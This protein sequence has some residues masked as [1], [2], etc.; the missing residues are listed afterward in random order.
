MKDVTDNELIKRLCKKYKFLH[1]STMNHK[2]LT[3]IV[4]D[5]NSMKLIRESIVIELCGVKVPDKL[6]ESQFEFEAFRSKVK[7]SL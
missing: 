6:I 4:I 3:Y 1:V 5:D 7:L 2:G